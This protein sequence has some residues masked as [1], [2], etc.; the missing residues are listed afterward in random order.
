MNESEINELWKINKT[1]FEMCND[2]KYKVENNK[3]NQDLIEFTSYFKN[4]CNGKRENISYLFKKINYTYAAGKYD[5]GILILFNSDLE[6]KISKGEIEHYKKQLSNDPSL[7][8]IIIVSKNKITPA[9]EASIKNS[10]IQ[11]F[12]DED[13]V[14]NVTK[15][16]LNP[17]FFL[18]DDNEKKELL[19]KYNITTILLPRM[20]Y[21]DP[22]CKYYGAE[23]G[24]IFKIIRESKSSGISIYYRV[25]V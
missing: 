18:L 21:D 9:A 23:R 6:N 13:L 8:K 3:L 16:E 2:R 19:D 4:K 1:I 12:L 17:K 14:Y 11:I 15:P 24:D 22:I 25:V 20:V 5:V 10:K 7:E